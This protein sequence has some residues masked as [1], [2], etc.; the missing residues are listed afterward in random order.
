M[1]LGDFSAYIVVEGEESKEYEVTVDSGGTQAT[2]WIGSEAGKKFSVMWRR[3]SINGPASRGEVTVDGVG[4]CCINLLPRDNEVTASCS[5][6]VRGTTQRDLMFCDLQLSDDDALVGKSVSSYLG[7][8]T[9]R[10]WFGTFHWQRRRQ[11]TILPLT[12]H[13][14]TYHE[15]SVKKLTTHCVGFGPEREREVRPMHWKMS[16]N[17]DPPLNFIF[18]YRPIG[19]LQANGVAPRPAPAIVTAVPGDPSGTQNSLS[20][21]LE[22]IALLENELKRLRNEVSD[23]SADRKPKRIKRECVEKHPIIHGEIIDLT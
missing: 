14:N 6:M 13:A 3:H 15:K 10:I 8:I 19:I 1:R 7:E 16:P 9:L 17:Q 2:C 23:E 22:R 18:K 11:G 4:C 20:G 12:S 21:V 5:R